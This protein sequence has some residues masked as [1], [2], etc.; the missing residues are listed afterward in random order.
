MTFDCTLKFQIA[1]SW[2][3]YWI[4]FIPLLIFIAND[5]FKSNGTSAN[6]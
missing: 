1:L 5:F 2:H 6:F 4:K 3:V